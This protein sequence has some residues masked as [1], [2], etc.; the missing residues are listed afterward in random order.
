MNLSAPFICQHFLEPLLN[1]L[2]Y[3][4]YLFGNEAEAAAIGQALNLSCTDLPSIASH[5]ASLA[6]IAS[7]T[8]RTV[9]ITHG[10]EATHVVTAGEHR[11]F[12][13]PTVAAHEIVDTNGAGDAFVG[14]F[15]SQLVRGR[16]LDQCVNAGHYTAQVII[17]R[18]GVSFPTD[19]PTHL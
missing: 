2:P 18:S 19:R 14:G 7:A 17:R 16:S 8:P 3:V 1:A 11:S 4:D 6:R 9:V 12:P 13:V 10:A 15:L 5:L